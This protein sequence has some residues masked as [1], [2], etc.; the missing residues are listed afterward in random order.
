LS[1]IPGNTGKI[2]PT[3]LC[4]RGALPTLDTAG[5]WVWSP[6][7]GLSGSVPMGFAK[8][9]SLDMTKGED[10][11]SQITKP[12]TFFRSTHPT[13]RGHEERPDNAPVSFVSKAQLCKRGKPQECPDVLR[14]YGNALVVTVKAPNS[15]LR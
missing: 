9:E 11:Q 7:D 4:E 12:I 6:V 2:P 3:P 1:I 10:I 5:F 14:S 13:G 8:T 15:S